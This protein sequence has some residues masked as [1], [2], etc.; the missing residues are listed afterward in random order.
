MNEHKKLNKLDHLVG[1]TIKSVNTK[2][3]NLH[4][5]WEKGQIQKSVIKSR[6]PKNNEEVTVYD[7][8]DKNNL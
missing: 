8:L 6:D 7:E 4:I 1:R 2:G 3:G 5:E